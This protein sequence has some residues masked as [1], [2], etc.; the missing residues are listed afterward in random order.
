VAHDG[1]YETSPGEHIIIIFL[2]ISFVCLK[3]YGFLNYW[4]LSTHFVY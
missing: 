1:M 3:L 4:R 2:A